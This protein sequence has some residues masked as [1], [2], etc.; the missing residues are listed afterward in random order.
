[1]LAD[2]ALNVVEREVLRLD[3][4][5]PL[6][7][8]RRHLHLPLFEPRHNSAPSYQAQIDGPRADSVPESP[9]AESD[10][11]SPHPE[12]GGAGCHVNADA[13][14]ASVA[15]RFCRKFCRSEAA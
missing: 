9:I 4:W 10:G 15:L 5:E 1:Q 13:G 14:L 6:A 7:T 3:W 12:D 11:L 8:P 2:A